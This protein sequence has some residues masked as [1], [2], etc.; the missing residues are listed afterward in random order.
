MSTPKFG[1][2]GRGDKGYR[3]L[4]L[5]VGAAI[6]GLILVFAILAIVY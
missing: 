1:D 2:G 3:R 4:A 5:G 6:V